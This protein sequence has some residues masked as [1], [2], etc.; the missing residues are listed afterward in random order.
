MKTWHFF[1]LW[2]ALALT[3]YINNK[4]TISMQ[5]TDPLRP[6]SSRHQFLSSHCSHFPE[7]FQRIIALT[8][9]PLGS[10]AHEIDVPSFKNNGGALWGASRC[11]NFSSWQTGQVYFGPRMGT[12]P[13]KT[14]LRQLN[15]SPHPGRWQDHGVSSHQT[16]SI[17]FSVLSKLTAFTWKT[18]PTYLPYSWV[19]LHCLSAVISLW[20]PVSPNNTKE[21]QL[22]GQSKIKVKH[23][24]TFIT[25]NLFYSYTEQCA[26]LKVPWVLLERLNNKLFM[27]ACERTLEISGVFE[28]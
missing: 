18:R 6:S 24:I 10:G 16:C 3:G 5:P 22:P 27:W 28:L 25:E 4:W 12:R 23:I 13:T 1:I 19:I 2:L 20:S 8:N 17:T 21:K 14:Q 11:H 15:Q 7:R 26:T 9:H